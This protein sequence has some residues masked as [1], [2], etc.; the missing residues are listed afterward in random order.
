MPPEDVEV[1]V[2]VT[3]SMQINATTWAARRGGI[4]RAAGAPPGLGPDRSRT[5]PMPQP[6]AA[7]GGPKAAPSDG[8]PLCTSGS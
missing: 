1:S 7:R 3:T 5:D 4:V 2:P 6:R 8:S